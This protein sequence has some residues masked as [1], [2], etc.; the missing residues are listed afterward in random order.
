MSHRRHKCWRQNT[1]KLW[2][3]QRK[4]LRFNSSELT[5]VRSLLL[6]FNIFFL[7]GQ[8]HEIF[9]TSLNQKLHLGHIWTG[10]NG[11]AKFCLHKV[12]REIRMSD[13]PCNRWLCWHVLKYSLTMR[14]PCQRSPWQDRMRA[15]CRRSCWLRGHG[16]GVVVDHPDTVSV[17][18][19]TTWTRCR[20]RR[21]L[22]R[23]DNDYVDTFENRW[24][25]LT[26]F[27][28]TIRWKKVNGCVYEP[29]SNSLR[30]W[31]YPYLE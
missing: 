17:Y 25:N 28:G 20:R 9:E 27:K 3:C 7:K 15:G 30:I 19:L 29:C 23:H 11:F 13:C 22:R 21:W 16:V 12:I 10:K 1:K 6:I 31:K 8:Y 5:A 26:D 14:T 2:K 4:T 18:S 24:R